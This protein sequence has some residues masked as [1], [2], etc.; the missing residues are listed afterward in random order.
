MVVSDV[1]E[2]YLN[3]A[4]ES[5]LLFRPTL[6]A[7]TRRIIV[8]GR[9]VRSLARNLRNIDIVVST[10]VQLCG[11]KLPYYTGSMRSLQAVFPPFRF[12]RIT[13]LGRKEEWKREIP[14]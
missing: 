10:E 7:A 2:P 1:S 3:Q 8:I 4:N 12:L 11:L 14:I 5:P 13:A 9:S 6:Y